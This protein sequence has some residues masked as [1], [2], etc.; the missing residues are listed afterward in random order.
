MLTPRPYFR[1]V[2]PKGGEVFI[3][4]LESGGVSDWVPTKSENVGLDLVVNTGTATVEQTA[5]SWSKC[6][7]KEASAFA[8]RPGTVSKN[9][10]DIV[11]GASAVRLRCSDSASLS[12]RNPP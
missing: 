6:V 7:S 11:N 4:T 9:T 10:S 5:S 8:W 3:V 2:H 1:E 12:V